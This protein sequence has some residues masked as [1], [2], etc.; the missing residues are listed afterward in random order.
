[1][2]VVRLVAKRV[3]RALFFRRVDSLLKRAPRIVPGP[4]LAPDLAPASCASRAV[5]ARLVG[6]G[7]VL[8]LFKNCGPFHACLVLVSCF[9][10]VVCAE[11]VT[12]VL[13]WSEVNSTRRSRL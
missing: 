13:F 11:W 2:P 6:W 5:P 1:M 9:V 10:R 3:A 8:V 7:S 4:G 12:L